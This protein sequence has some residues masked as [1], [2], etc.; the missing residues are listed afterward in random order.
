MMD[1][2]LFDPI[3]LGAWLFGLLVIICV[4]QQFED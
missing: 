3:P 4:L 1:S 2:V